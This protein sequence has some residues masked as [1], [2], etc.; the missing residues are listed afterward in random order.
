MI[1]II[2]NI[3]T[4]FIITDDYQKTLYTLE[5]L[6]LYFINNEITIT[7]DIA[8]KLLKINLNLYNLIGEIVTKNYTLISD[9]DIEL[10]FDDE[11]I[12]ALIKV[13]AI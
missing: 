5:E 13:I 12:L 3:N 10:L 2:N 8:D 6:Q 4:N 7:T 9:G 11:N 1:D